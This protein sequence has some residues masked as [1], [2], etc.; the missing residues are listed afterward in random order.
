[1]QITISDTERQIVLRLLDEELGELRSGARRTHNPE[2]HDGLK[3]EEAILR[4]LIGK[5]RADN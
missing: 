1:M 5:L 3:D 4:E 2:W